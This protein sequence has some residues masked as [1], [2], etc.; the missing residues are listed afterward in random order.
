MF[1]QMVLDLFKPY[2]VK[3][4][5]PRILIV[6]IIAMEMLTKEAMLFAETL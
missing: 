6:N 2:N 5:L 3:L 1:D 4:A